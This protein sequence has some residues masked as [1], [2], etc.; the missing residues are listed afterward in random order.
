MPLV[1]YLW[2]GDVQDELQLKE[3]VKIAQN[4]NLKTALYSGEKTISKELEKLLDYVKTGSYQEEL[5]A[6]DSKLTNQKLIKT[7]GN[8][9]ITYL[10]QK[11]RKLW[12]LVVVPD[13]QLF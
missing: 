5:G 4:R 12:F 3:L 9:D 2:V 6:L 1:F 8:E 7:K 11:W 10:F 13:F